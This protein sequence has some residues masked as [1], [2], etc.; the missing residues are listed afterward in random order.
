GFLFRPSPQTLES[1][2][3]L[4]VVQQYEEIL[5]ALSNFELEASPTL[6]MEHVNHPARPLSAF[7][8]RI[9]D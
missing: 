5:D 7:S 4:R 6:R 2:Q 3:D 1:S 8:R 9:S